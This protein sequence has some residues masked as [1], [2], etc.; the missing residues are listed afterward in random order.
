MREIFPR[1]LSQTN[2]TKLSYCSKLFENMHII[3]YPFPT[4]RITKLYFSPNHS[5]FSLFI[6]GNFYLYLPYL[7]R[8]LHEL[9]PHLVFSVH[10]FALIFI[11][12]ANIQYSQNVHEYASAHCGQTDTNVGTHMVLYMKAIELYQVLVHF[13]LVF[14]H[15]QL[16][17]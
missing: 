3:I 12:F 16:F 10:D 6:R 1:K 4:I 11:L 9:I 2:L 15:L 14:V 13:Y 7:H 17:I 8:M 5:N